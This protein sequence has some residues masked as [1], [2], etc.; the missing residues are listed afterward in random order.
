MSNMDLESYSLFVRRKTWSSQDIGAVRVMTYN[1]LAD[2]LLNEHSH[3]YRGIDPAHLAPECRRAKVIEEIKCHSPDFIALQEVEINFTLDLEGYESYFKVKTG[4]NMDGCLTL[5]DA[6]QYEKIQVLEGEYKARSFD[7]TELYSKNNVFLLVVL[8]QRTSGLYFLVANTHISFT[9]N[10]GDVQL[11]QLYLFFQAVDRVK[12]QYRNCG[13]RLILCG[14]YNLKPN[15]GL[16]HFIAQGEIDLKYTCRAGLLG[17]RIKDKLPPYRVFQIMTKEF[18]PNTTMDFLEINSY[19]KYLNQTQPFISNGVIYPEYFPRDGEIPSIISH[20]LNLESAV[21]AVLGCEGFPTSVV[22][23]ELATVDYIWVDMMQP[24][25]V[26]MPPSFHSISA[27]EGFPS[28]WF[29][30]DHLSVVAEFNV[31]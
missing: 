28:A 30:S 19:Y 16:Y 11:A 17:P 6:R 27:V 7:P 10:R 12:F 3:L 14:D 1:V 22:A 24:V 8:R 4:D 5:W 13:L 21:K 9:R 26:L 20:P 31:K 18:Q 25:R 2:Y 15:S 23:R 29:P